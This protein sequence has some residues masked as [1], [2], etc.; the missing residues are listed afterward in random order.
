MIPIL[1]NA[2]WPALFL[3]KHL[4]A[5]WPILIG[6]TIEYGFIRKL[7]MLTPLQALW[8]DI[9]MNG[10]SALLGILLIPLAG[11]LWEFFPGLV[12]DFFFHSGTF[13]PGTW[14]ATFFMSVAINAIVEWF[15]LKRF[16][17]QNQLGL[18][19]FWILY[20]ANFLTVAVAFVSLIYAQTDPGCGLTLDCI[21]NSYYGK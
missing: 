7:T 1:A 16:F 2:I 6:L 15:V 9:A 4:I 18:L 3:E 10:A 12:L 21:Y 20:I 17:K 11:I 13:N 14:I 8:A 5:P 19:A